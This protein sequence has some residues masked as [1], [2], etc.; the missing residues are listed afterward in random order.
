MKTQPRPITSLLAALFGVALSS[1]VNAQTNAFTYQGNLTDGGSPANGLYD[2]RFELSSSPSNSLLIGVITNTA[3]DI[4]NGLFTV[5][6]DFGPGAFD[7]GDRWLEIGAVTNGPAP[8]GFS[9]LTPR[10]QITS[11]PYALKAAEATSVDMGTISDPTFLGATDTQPLELS[12]N[13]ESGFRLQ[14]PTLG[15]A[16]NIIG[17]YSGNDVGAQTE[18]AVIAGG[19]AS[20]SA[21][22]VGVGSDWSAIGGGWDNRVADKSFYATIAGG[23]QNDIGMDSDW[24]T[25]GGGVGNSIASNS[26][27]ATIAGGRLNDVGANSDHT[28]LGGGRGNTVVDSTLY[29]TIAGGQDNVLGTGADH[30]AIGGGVGNT[31]ASNANASVIGGGETNTVG[32]NGYGNVI[33][34]GERNTIADDAVY[35][36]I[37]GGTSNDMGE[38]ASGSVIGGGYRFFTGT[39]TAGAELPAGATSWTTLSDRNQKKDVRPADCSSIL[40]RLV[41]IPVSHW[42]YTWEASDSASH[43]G[44]MAQDFKAAF[45]PGR[46][47]TRL[48]TLEVDGVALAAIQGL[49]EKVDGRMQSAEV[50]IREL[51]GENAELRQTVDELKQLVQAMNHKLNGGAK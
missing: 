3:T 35:A 43:L 45:Y 16:P 46:D 17:G 18:G 20:G 25:I 5:T 14:Y 1:H 29:A 27:Y 26:F 44:P 41:R 11:T 40:E 51:R 13:N 4:S 8:A 7:G 34:G 23:R 48:S 33:G 2:L 30:S 9:T 24:S 42:R 50:N 28:A 6:L 49:N 15:S 10:Q 36:T 39:G 37:A 19:G 31:I 22:S 32:I 38:N 12:V 47:D 21:N